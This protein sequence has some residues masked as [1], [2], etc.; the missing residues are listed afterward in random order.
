[1]KNSLKLVQNMLSVSG[2]GSKLE[3][4]ENLPPVFIDENKVREVLV[5]LITNAIHAMSAGDTVFLRTNLAENRDHIIIEIEDTGKGIPPEFIDHIFDPFFSTKGTEGTGLGL[6]ISYGI[7]K[8]HK[9]TINVRSK[10]GVGTTF[11][12][13][14][15]SYTTKE[16][17][18]GRPENYGN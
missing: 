4:E 18:N 15:P 1:M 6:S 17:K 10:V 11:T 16:V 5:N 12:I 7:I 14:L 3:L 8:K 13:K 2:I 9:G